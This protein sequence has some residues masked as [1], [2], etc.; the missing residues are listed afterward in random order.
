MPTTTLDAV[1]GSELT[2]R[3][4]IIEYVRRG[5]VDGIDLASGGDP[6]ALVK[7]LSAPG[8]PAMD[9]PLSVLSSTLTLRRIRVR[10]SP[11]KWRRAMLEMVYSNDFG[12]LLTATLTRVRGYLGSFETSVLPGTRQPFRTGYVAGGITFPEDYLVLNLPRPMREVTIS[13]VTVGDPPVAVENAIGYVNAGT[14]RG[15]AKGHWLVAASETNESAYES[16]SS[17]SLSILTRAYEDWG[18]LAVYRDTRTGR[19]VPIAE[20]DRITLANRAYEYG[21][22]VLSPTGVAVAS[23][24]TVGS[25]G[26]IRV[27]PFPTLDFAT[28]L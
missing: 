4:D 8:M 23:T 9:A 13:A 19:I 10:P 12:Q 5:W 28:I 25:K 22:W 15:L 14:Y 3:G 17:Y 1:R 18:F 6:D 16:F 2:R 21:V 27:D 7:V 20:A 11:T 24:A 26:I